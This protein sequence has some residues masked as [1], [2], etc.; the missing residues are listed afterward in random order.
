M[1]PY[2]VLAPKYLTSTAAGVAPPMAYLER[3][4]FLAYA[5][6]KVIDPLDQLVKQ[7]GITLTD[8][9]DGDIT[10]ATYQDKLYLLPAYV[11]SGRT[12]LW[13]NKKLFADAG[14]D[15][16]KPPKTW[17][18]LEAVERKITV[19]EGNE[20]KKVAYIG[21]NFKRTLYSAGG[22]WV[23]DDGRTLT[24]QNGPGPD[25]IDWVKRRL[26]SIYS[27]NAARA[28]F[29]GARS[30]AAQRGGFFSGEVA[31]T[32][33]HH[34]I[35]FDANT[36]AKDLQM[37][38]S[39]QPSLRPEFPPAVAEFFAGYGITA[40][41]KTPSEAMQFLKYISYEDAGVGWFFRQQL[42]PGPVKKQNQHPDLRKLNPDWDSML[43]D[44]ARDVGIANTGVDRDL[45]VLVNT[46]FADVLNG[47]AVSR[48]ALTEAAAAGQ[49]KVNAFWASISS[50]TK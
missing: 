21:D 23:S 13:R 41:T 42:R 46:M 9:Y 25:A 17:D 18:D 4:D 14:L 29:T 32:A 12:L 22:K 1:S 6:R 10:N 11:G 3:E 19:K 40:G 49:Q 33:S 38:I 31:M 5:L 36:Y 27:G 8:Y 48:Q 44:M 28:A 2:D 15:P 30:A 47:K 7:H 34:G 26:D 35:L 39:A 16:N 45:N 43:A 20:L 37:G 50:A 24:F